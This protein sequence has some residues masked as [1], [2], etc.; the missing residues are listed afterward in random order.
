MNGHA[1]LQKLIGYGTGAWDGS[2]FFESFFEICGRRAKGKRPMAQGTGLK[3][4]LKAQGAR[5]KVKGVRHK[6]Q[7]KKG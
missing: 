6:A 3:K 5:Q 4:R 1:Y 7:G 2:D